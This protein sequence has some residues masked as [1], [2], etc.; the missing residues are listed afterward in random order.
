MHRT[1]QGRIGRL[2]RNN[3]PQISPRKAIRDIVRAVTDAQQVVIQ[4]SPELPKEC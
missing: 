4:G 3:I 1:E 2:E